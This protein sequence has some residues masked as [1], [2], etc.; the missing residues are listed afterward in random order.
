MQMPFAWPVHAPVWADDVTQCLGT[1]AKPTAMD[2][3]H[4]LTWRGI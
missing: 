3:K 4:S 1:G 2:I